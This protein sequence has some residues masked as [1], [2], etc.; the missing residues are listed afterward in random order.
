MILFVLMGQRKCDY[1]GQYAP[2]ALAVM[3]EYGDDDNP[4][5]LKE[6]KEKYEKSK[7]FTSLVIIAVDVNG[8][9]IKALLNPTMTV[10]KGEIEGHLPCP[11][12]GKTDTPEPVATNYPGEYRITCNYHKGGCGTSTA[13]G[14]GIEESWKNWDRRS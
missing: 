14:D 11:S 13:G 5:Y 8:A 12:C 3:D 6:E 2:E 1:P 9:K 7:E 4:D 10:L